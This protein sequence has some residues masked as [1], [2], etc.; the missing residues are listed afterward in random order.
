MKSTIA[1]ID[2]LEVN[3]KKLI[4]KQ[5]SLAAENEDLKTELASVTNQQKA[6]FNEIERLQKENQT[7]KN[8]N[9]ILG[10]TEFKRET[11][12]K[13]NSLIKEIDQCIVQLAE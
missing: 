7:L 1:Y 9:A 12:L 10:S 2:L 6:L 5:K 4:D 3:I 11:K 8:A 13:I